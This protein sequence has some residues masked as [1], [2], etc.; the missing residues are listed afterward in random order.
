MPG[1]PKLG[2]LHPASLQNWL[3]SGSSLCNRIWPPVPRMTTLQCSI[4]R[5]CPSSCREGGQLSASEKF[6]CEREREWLTGVLGGTLLYYCMTWVP[7]YC[8]LGDLLEVCDECGSIFI[9]CE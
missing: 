8:T 9:L 7:F 3:P 2:I 6:L 5:E 1:V 4:S